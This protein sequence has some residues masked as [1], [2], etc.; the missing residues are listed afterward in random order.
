MV[1]PLVS[2]CR[3]GAQNIMIGLT[4][5]TVDECLTVELVTVAGD[6]GY[7]NLTRVGPK[8]AAHEYVAPEGDLAM[9]A[10]AVF[11][12]ADRPEHMPAPI[13]PFPP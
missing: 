3:Y 10:R 8:K 6:A 7:E 2:D 9:T 11:R 5:H 13:G 12:A 4:S 1:S